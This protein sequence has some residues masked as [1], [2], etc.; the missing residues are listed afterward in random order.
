MSLVEEE[1]EVPGYEFIISIV[2]SWKMHAWKDTEAIWIAFKMRLILSL[3]TI[4]NWKW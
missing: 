4:Q 2:V 3:K 1:K